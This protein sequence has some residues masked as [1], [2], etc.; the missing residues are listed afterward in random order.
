VVATVDETFQ[1]DREE[2]RGTLPLCPNIRPNLVGRGTSATLAG[3]IDSTAAYS[4]FLTLVAWLHRRDADAIAYLLEENRTLGAQL[5]QRPLHL[6]D[7]QRRR[8]DV[9]GHRLGRAGLH[10]LASLVMPDTILRCHRQVVA[11]KD[12]FAEGSAASRGPPRDSGVNHPGG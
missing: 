4:F 9:L 6:T 8:L 12:V 11:R 5:D 3:M 2:F 10:R 7:D 1:F